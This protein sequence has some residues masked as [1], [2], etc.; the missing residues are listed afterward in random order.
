MRKKFALL[1][2]ASIMIVTF[3][4]CEGD[5]FQSISDFLG[6]TSTNV[7]IDGEIVSVPTGNIDD[8]GDTLG[9]TSNV[10]VTDDEV[11]AVRDSVEKILKSTGETEAARELLKELV[12]STEIPDDVRDAMEDLEGELGLD[13]GDLDIADKGDLAAA[14]LLKDLKDKRLAMEGEQNPVVK[15]EMREQIVKDARVVVEFVKKASPIGDL[16]V[17]GALT[18]LLEGLIDERSMSRMVSRDVED[19]FDADEVFEYVKPLFTMYFNVIDMDSNGI[20]TSS[21]VK[22]LGKEFAKLRNAYETMGASLE[23]SS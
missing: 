12:L 9:G 19:D 13:A 7:L 11:V 8:L 4:S 16:D 21:E 22:K 5:I 23:G 14:I 15:Q 2:I 10:D 1:I 6:G 17:T 20:I 18:G 3:V